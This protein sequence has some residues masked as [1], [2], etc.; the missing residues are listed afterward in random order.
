MNH[1]HSLYLVSLCVGRFGEAAD[2]WEDVPVVFYCEEGREEDARRG[3]G[4][5]ASALALFSKRFGVRYPYERYA[6]VAVSEFPGGM[7]N[8]TCTTQTDACLVSAEAALD[9]DLDLLVSH[10]LAHQ[11]FGDLLTC[12][13]WSHAWLNEGFATY[14]EYVFTE[15]DKGRDEADR[16]WELNKRA[17]FDEDAHRYRRPIVCSTY[18][19]PTVLFDRHLYEKGGW[20]LHMLRREL[21]EEAWWRAI[22]HY[23]RRFRDQS[24]ET[25]DL[26]GAVEQATGRNVRRFFDQWVY[27]TGYPSLE[28]RSAW[29]AAAGRASLRVRQTQADPFELPLTVRFTGKGGRWTREF[30]ET[31]KEK[32]R[33]LSWRLPGAPALV[34]VD[35]AHVLLKKLEEHK[36]LACWRAQLESARSGQSRSQAARALAR[37]GDAAA[38]KALE[39][40][41]RRDR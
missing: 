39:A 13:D 9:T 1:P 21:G 6:Q 8:T 41:A 3:F 29:D 25:S 23:L 18:A 34:E 4:K 31:V 28:T 38:V 30:T 33:T 15:H 40:C 20:V 35:P 26:I 11:W 19:H 10:E 7:E 14:C 37:W 17:Y 12:R 32:D 24:V 2:K 16:E 27:G 22:Q 36:P 5:T